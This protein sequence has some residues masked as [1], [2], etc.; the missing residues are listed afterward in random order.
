M[1]VLTLQPLRS[2]G[3]AYMMRMDSGQVPTRLEGKA[4]AKEL[5]EDLKADLKPEPKREPRQVVSM[6]DQKPVPQGLRWVRLV[7]DLNRRHT[8][9]RFD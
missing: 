8:Y 7:A 1:L 2:R 5:Q 6:E 3:L 9:C 4:L